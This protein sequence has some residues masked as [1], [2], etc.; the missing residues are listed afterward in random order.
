[1]TSI[2]IQVQSAATVHQLASDAM[3]AARAAEIANQRVSDFINGL[4]GGLGIEPAAYHFDLQA[5]AFIPN[6]TPPE[7]A[8]VPALEAAP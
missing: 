7:A 8:P 2:P 4:A 3:A 5:M 6:E 1:M